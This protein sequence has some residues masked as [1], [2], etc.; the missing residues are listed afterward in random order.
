MDISNSYCDQPKVDISNIKHNNITQDDIFYLIFEKLFSNPVFSGGALLSVAGFFWYFVDWIWNFGQERFRERFCTSLQLTNENIT[1]RW[2][3]DHIN[4]NSKWETRNLSVESK[5]DDTS[6]GALTLKHKFIPGIGNHYF[7][8]K[9]RVIYFERTRD[10]RNL[11]NVLG[12]KRMETVTLSTYGGSKE[13]WQQFLNDASK[14]CLKEIHKGLAIYTNRSD[15]WVGND[16]PKSKRVLETVVLA[17]GISESV[18]D[19]IEN[20]LSSQKWYHDRGIP[21]RRGYLLYGPPGTGK[22]SFIAALASTFGYGIAVLSLTTKFLTDT[23]LNFLLN[24]APKKSFVILE[25]IDAAFK[26]R[27]KT[28]NDDKKNTVDSSIT[29]SGLLNAIDGI[30]SSEERILFMT[31]NYK[32]HLDSAIIRPGRIDFEVYLGHCTPEMIK[33]MFKRFYENVS[34]ELINTFCEG[35]SKFDKTF[36]PAE[37]QKHLILY[38]NSPEAAIKHVNDLS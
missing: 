33:K 19:D 6:P 3:I 37:L 10:K 18:Y 35:T 17:D 26:N 1:Y 24:N 30:T 22:S 31:T 20:F 13:F 32:E 36:S 14:A 12:S 2:V 25:D 16:N 15:Y 23:D 5:L 21:Y 29:L 38:K 4:R 9:N 27:E 28:E 8:Y 34:E 11:P 7:Y